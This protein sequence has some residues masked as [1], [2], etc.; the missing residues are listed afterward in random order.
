MR[1][2]VTTLTETGYYD[3]YKREIRKP[4]EGTPREA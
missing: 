3:D 2:T 1:S 4:P